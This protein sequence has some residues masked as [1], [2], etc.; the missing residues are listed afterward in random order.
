MTAQQ[1]A[2]RKICKQV[3]RDPKSVKDVAAYMRGWNR[4]DK[5]LRK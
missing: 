5:R 3:G 4:T 1:K 2:F